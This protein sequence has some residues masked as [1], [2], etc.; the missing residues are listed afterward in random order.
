MLLE[1]VR[2]IV[3]ETIQQNAAA[4]MIPEIIHAQD[5]LAAGDVHYGLRQWKS[6]YERY[7]AAYRYAVKQPV[8][9]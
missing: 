6:A 5:E 2:E 4:G 1:L 7:S 8:T 9:R 3:D